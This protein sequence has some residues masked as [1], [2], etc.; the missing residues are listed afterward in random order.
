MGTIET[1]ICEGI[2]TDNTGLEFLCW[3]RFFLKEMIELCVVNIYLP[4][5]VVL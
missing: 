2:V 5:S 3:E 1:C 4:F